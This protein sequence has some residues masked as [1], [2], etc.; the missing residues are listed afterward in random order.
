MG[1]DQQPDPVPGLPLQRVPLVSVIIPTWNAASFLARTLDSVFAQTW[2]SFEVIIVDDGS[3]D[4]TPMLLQ[5]YTDR[6]VVVDVEHSGGPSRPRNR[7]IEQARGDFIAIF[8][9]D[10]LMEPDKIATS[11]E[12]LQ[13]VP[14]ADLVFTNFRSIDANDRTLSDDYLADYHEFRQALIPTET[15][16]VSILDPDRALRL[17]IHANF[18]GASSVTC[19]R[20]ALNRTGPFDESMKNADDIDMWMRMASQG[21][22]FVFLDRV[23]HSY[24]IN[25]G[26][27]TSRGADRIP[28]MIYGLQKQLGVGHSRQV[29]AEIKAAI[30]RLYAGRAW[31][32]RKQRRLH[33]ARGCY[34]EALR[35]GAGPGVLPG[36]IM[37]WAMSLFRRE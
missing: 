5:E 14:H 28:G 18:I 4:S 27:V 36:L 3:T 22:V 15:P 34:R 33:E 8:D 12:A 31:S 11:L 21:R 35:R 32:L 24:R 7:G 19:R 1:V 29:E 30:G 6:V 25:P 2:P 16:D 17:L 13:A 9:S 20:E 23:L 26:G 10:D 37:T